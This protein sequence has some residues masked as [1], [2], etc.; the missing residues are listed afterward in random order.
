MG[1]LRLLGGFNVPHFFSF[2]LVFFVVFLGFFLCEGVG[3][4]RLVSFVLNVASGS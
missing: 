3:C 4:C 1:H 2:V